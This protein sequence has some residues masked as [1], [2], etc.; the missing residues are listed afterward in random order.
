M[1]TPIAGCRQRGSQI[2]FAYAHLQKGERRLSSPDFGATDEL[3]K[4]REWM[5]IDNGSPTIYA[6]IKAGSVPNGFAFQASGAETLSKN[7]APVFRFGEGDPDR[8]SFPPCF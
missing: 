8:V 7:N 6:R 5:V 2:G 3:T 4:E 1:S